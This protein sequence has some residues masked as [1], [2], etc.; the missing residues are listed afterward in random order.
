[1][2]ILFI[3]SHL[4]IPQLY[5]G[6]Q[7]STDQLCRHLAERGHK[8][9]L[10]CGLT[11]SGFF[12]WKSRL[13]LHANT[14]LLQR[15]IAQDTDLGYT[16]WRTW[17]PRIEAEYVVKKEK[18]DVVVIKSGDLV[19]IADA[20]KAIGVPLV[21]QLHD[22]EFH[23]HNG[24][25][26]KLGKFTC[27]A[28][29]HFTAQKYKQAY[30][31][32]PYVVYPFILAEKYRT[33]STRENVTFINPHPQKGIDV[34]LRV[35][36]KCPHIPFAFV[37]GWPLTPEYKAK[38][39]NTLIQFPN[40]TLH[41]ATDDMKQ[42]YGKCRILL[43][44]SRWEEAYGRVVS[45]AQMSGIP[46][47]ASNRGGLPESVGTGGILLDPDATEEWV[48]AINRLWHDETYYESISAMAWR[49]SIRP[50]LDIDVQ[51]E[52]LENIFQQAIEL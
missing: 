18:P 23:L 7:N 24:D 48:I 20:V 2:K 45:E 52:M 33:F 49:H 12:G 37:E 14:L 13:K 40:I 36:E 42:V 27:I 25:F 4:H 34:A 9:I 29:S 17:F 5:G 50:E 15:K 35:A 43:A 31:V 6:L 46:V 21:I 26:N 41:P 28:N 3:T 22:V 11:H 1:M 39:L 8:I 38:L 47:I 19:R 51:I 32:E 16:V 10:L 44:P 30:G